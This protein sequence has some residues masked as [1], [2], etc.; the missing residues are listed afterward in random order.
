[1]FAPGRPTTL[2]P[3]PPAAATGQ[4]TDSVVARDLPA[5]QPARPPVQYV[6]PPGATQPSDPAPRPIRRTTEAEGMHTEPP[7]PVRRSVHPRRPSEPL[8][9]PVALETGSLSLHAEPRPR[10]VRPP[11]PLARS[12]ATP[13]LATEIPEAMRI[14]LAALVRRVFL[15]SDGL[16]VRSVLFCPIA[17]EPTGDV[18]WRVAELL[19]SQ[20][21]RRVAFVEDGSCKVR[22]GSSGDGHGLITRVGWYPSVEKPVAPGPTASQRE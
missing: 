4:P 22:C 20:S 1:F 9:N 7:Q 5:P 8:A 6:W 3:E 17:G 21:Q 19:A 2:P 11:A 15:E 14:E 18:A 16:A 12:A 10:P 13:P